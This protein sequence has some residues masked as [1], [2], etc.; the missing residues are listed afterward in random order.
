VE[1]KA[2]AELVGLDAEAMVVESVEEMVENLVAEAQATAV[3]S[4]AEPV[5]RVVE[6]VFEQQTTHVEARVPRVSVMVW[7]ISAVKTMAEECPPPP[8]QT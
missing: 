2:N 1:E 5:V 3:N 7:E 8:S 6:L 4:L